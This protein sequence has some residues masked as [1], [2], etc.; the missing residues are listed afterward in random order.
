MSRP[1]YGSTIFNNTTR[2]AQAH[3]GESAYDTLKRWTEEDVEN[4]FYGRP[5]QHVNKMHQQ[6]MKVAREH[7][8]QIFAV[9][10]QVQEFKN[11]HMKVLRTMEN[12]QSFQ[13]SSG[14]PYLIEIQ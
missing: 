7:K 9:Q 1:I 10:T 11:N 8:Q 5:P 14:N 3:N 13:L 2:A 12:I 6:I 4:E